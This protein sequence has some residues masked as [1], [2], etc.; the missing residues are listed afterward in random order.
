[1][2]T[3]AWILIIVAVVLVVAAVAWLLWS[4]RRRSAELRDRFGPEYDRTVEEAPSRRRAEK[5]LDE[6]RERRERLDIRPL[7]EAARERYAEQWRLAQTQF[8]D[9]PEAAVASADLLVVSVMRDRGYPVDE[10]EQRAADVSVDHP[11]VVESYRT[12][13]ELSERSKNGEAST[14]DLRQAMRH[15][16]TLFDELLEAPAD[17]PLTRERGEDRVATESSEESRR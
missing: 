11:Q 17:E 3:W 4:R 5:E 6:R 14:E 1:M 10:F 8:V 9:S 7:P 13:H 15:Y 12:A 16:R 2:P